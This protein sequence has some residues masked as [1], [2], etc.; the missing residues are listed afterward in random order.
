MVF[1]LNLTQFLFVYGPRAKIF[2]SK[3]YFF[4]LWKYDNMFIGDLE[5]IEQGYTYF[6]Y[7][8]QLV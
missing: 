8:L 2:I 3:F 1:G 6:H 7:I 5:N 4:K